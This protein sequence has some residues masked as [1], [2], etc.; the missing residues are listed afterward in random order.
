[1]L[2]SNAV[3]LTFSHILGLVDYVVVDDNQ[4]KGITQDTN[5]KVKEGFNEVKG[6]NV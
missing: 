1:M 2:T 5:E 3:W 6:K 4:V